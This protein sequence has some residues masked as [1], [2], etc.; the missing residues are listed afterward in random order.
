METHQASVILSPAEILETVSAIALQIQ[1]CQGLEDILHGAIATVRSQLHADRVLIYQFLPNHDA[2]VSFESIIHPW[3]PIL[4]RLIDDPCFDAIWIER[5]Q[6][7]QITSMTDA[8][9]GTVDPCYV[10]LLDQLQVQANLV[11]PIFQHATLWGLMIVHQCSHPRQW[12]PVEFTLVQQVS[13][14]LSIA[15]Q[16]LERSHQTLMDCSCSLHTSHANTLQP[17]SLPTVAW[18]ESRSLQVQGDR[19]LAYPSDADQATNFRL[20]ADSV[21]FLVWVSDAEGRGIFFNQA[22]LAFKGRSLQQELGNGWSQGIHPDDWSRC[23]QTYQHALETQQAFRLEYRLQRADGE[24]RWILEQGTAYCSPTGA[25]TGFIGSCLDISERKQNEET[26]RRYE[27]IIS[28]TPDCVSLLD[29]NYVYQVVNQTYLTWNQKSYD[30]IVGHSVSELLGQEFFETYCKPMLD[31]C[32]AGETQCVVDSWLNYGDGERR[33]VRATYA[34]YVEM[35]GTIS[36]VVINVHDLTQLKHTE[37]ALR[38]SET[39]WQF[40]LEGSGDGVWDWDI[41]NGGMFFSRQWKAMLGYEED[42][43]SNCLSAW[44]SRIHPEDK[45]QC[46]ADHQAHFRGETAIYQNEHRLRC[47][48]GSYKWIFDRGKV[49]Q[50]GEGGLPLRMIGIHTDISDRKHAELALQFSQAKFEAL[51]TNMP[52]MVYR[53]FPTTPSEPHRFTF[54]S[55][56]SMELLEL[57]PDVLLH[58]ADALLDLIHPDDLA[59]F[60]ASVT[61]AVAHFLPWHWEGRITT[62]S[63]KQKWIQGNSQA[64][65]APEGEAWDGLLVDISDRKQAELQLQQQIEREKL[66]TAIAQH[67]RQTLDLNQILQTT[68]TEVRQFLQTDRVIIYRFETDWSGVVIAESVG[69]DWLSILGMQITD[70]YFVETQGKTYE[71]ERIKATDDIYQANFDPCHVELL[72]NMQVRAKLVV[73]IL[74]DQHLWGLLVAQHCRSPRHW[75]HDEIELQRQLATQIAIAL[76]QSELYQQVQALNTGLELQVAERTAQLQQALEFEALLK[77]ITDH[78]RDSLDEQKILQAT[79]E[80]LVQGLNINACDT[81]IYNA[82]HTTSTIAYEFTKNLSK[83]QG[84][85]FDIAQAPHNEVY[86]V[87]FGGMYANFVMFLPIPSGRSSIY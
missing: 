82:D 83:A 30:E 27:R 3:I 44:E 72:E 49:I 53:Y 74:Q 66:L 60:L 55:A 75:D 19:P 69:A 22:W 45:A 67:I 8:H 79:V 63:G 62:P 36:G 26:L 84:V 65:H 23:W 14:Q 37:E 68:V 47:K 13:L 61:Y 41:A 51:V 54:V 58:D 9:D 15:L 59:S 87:L 85:T 33:F 25:F 52:G 21:P 5:Y 64:Q 32:L 76:Q 46:W 24:Y 34:P 71:Q 17:V 1:Q 80:E 7:G 43:I 39:R 20:M 78:V 42:E 38:E 11:A 16:T 40:A 70:S 4:G 48:D 10:A 77:R 56:H 35:D 18:L 81:G 12:E 50:W 6:Q 73:P 57:A 28:A 2:V 29:R 31:R 86:P